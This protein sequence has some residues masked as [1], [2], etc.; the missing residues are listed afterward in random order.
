M[1]DFCLAD[2]LMVSETPSETGACPVPVTLDAT[3]TRREVR[4]AQRYYERVRFSADDEVV[5]AARHRLREAQKAH[6]LALEKKDQTF[7]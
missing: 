6:R 4:N 7:A 3:E 1:V 2:E 5:R